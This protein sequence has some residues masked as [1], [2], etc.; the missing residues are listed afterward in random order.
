MEM[1]DDLQYINN[2]GEFWLALYYISV[3]MGVLLIS[4]PVE[5]DSDDLNW[6]MR[7]DKYQNYPREV[8]LQKE[9]N[10]L[11]SKNGHCESTISGE[12]GENVSDK[13]ESGTAIFVTKET[14]I[15]EVVVKGKRKFG[16]NKTDRVHLRKIVKALFTLVFVDVSFAT[17]RLKVMLTEESA[18][19]GFNIMVKNSVLACLHSYYLLHMC[20]IRQRQ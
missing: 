15:C 16:L 6:E 3:G 20:Y 14:S 12:I 11:C 10:L 8:K 19:L 13:T 5:I 9:I 7:Q 4:Y 17:I 18:E 1:T 2:Y